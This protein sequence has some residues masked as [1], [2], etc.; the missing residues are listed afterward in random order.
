MGKKQMYLMFRY[1]LYISAN[2]DISKLY[3]NCNIFLFSIWNW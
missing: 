1:Y 2:K 3:K